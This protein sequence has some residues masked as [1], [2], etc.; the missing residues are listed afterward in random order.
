MSENYDPQKVEAEANKYWEDNRCFEVDEDPSKEKFYCLSMFPYPSGALHVGH[1]RNYTIGDVIARFQRMQGKNVLQPIGW[2]A[3]GLPAENAAIKNRIPPAKWT[4]ENIAHMKSQLKQLGFAY[5]WRRELTTCDADYYKW[6]Q[7]LFTRM[8]ENGIAYKKNAVVNWDP[9]DQTVLANEQVINGRGWRSGAVVERREIPQWFMKITDYAQELLDSL[10]DMDG[11]PDSVRTMQ[12]NWI[13][14]SEGVDIDFGVAGREDLLGVYTTRPDTIMGVTYMA[15]AADHPLALEA[16]EDDDE[17]ADFL[18]ECRRGPVAE[19][20]V[21]TMEKKGM[22]LPF[23]AV[24]PISGDAVPVLVANFVLMEYGT[25][26]VMGVP[27]HDQRDWE[28]AHAMNLPIVQVIRPADD[29]EVSLEES[30]FVEYG[31]VMNSGQFDNLDFEAAFDEVATYLEGMKRG[32]RRVNFRLRDWLVSRQRY[33]GAPIPA[34]DT[35]DG[36]VP[37]PEDQLPVALPQDVTPDGEGSP[38]VGLAGFV[39]TVDPA[40]G[41]PAKRETDTFDTF[42]ESSWYYARY[43]SWDCDSAMLDERARYWLPVDQYI[44]GV[45]HATLHLLYVRFYHRLMKSLGLVAEDEPVKNLLTQGMVNAQTFYRDVEGRRDW[46]NSDEVDI[47]RDDKGRIVSAA[48]K[49]DGQPVEIGGVEKMS[50]SKRNGVDPDKLIA[51]YGADTLRLFSVSD[52]PPDQGLEWADEGVDGAWKF[53]RRVWRMVG[54]H[55]AAGTPAALDTAALDKKQKALRGTVHQA[56]AKVADDVGRRYTFNTAIA[57][58]RGV[59]NELAKFDDT[60]PQ[61]LAVSRE[62]WDTVIAMLSPIAPHICHKLWFALGHEQPVIDAA[63]PVADSDA[64][65]TETV[66]IVVQVN[67]KLRAKVAM[68][69]DSDAAEMEKAARADANVQRYIADK[70]VRRVIVVPNK[71][72]NIVV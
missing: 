41:K 16:A 48:L 9:V 59:V 62:A 72:V 32:K 1:V 43:C 17:I 19:A 22:R 50:K 45:E 64:L 12:R 65:V 68:A 31:V 71:L 27:G 15:V 56:I 63:W 5:D 10:D 42:M 13:G 2:D 30:A 49:Q 66:D 3:F 24:H 4:Y 39:E 55:I 38:L 46:Y 67:G 25:G 26:A 51:R 40:T 57:A 37:V 21:E 69:P 29:S 70:E 35:E 7:W 20:D 60:S 18:D 33:W 61:G 58:V 23:Q 14:R 34:I 11:W 53:L 44:G 36:P 54:E 28:F 8:M 52:V 6:E 47:R